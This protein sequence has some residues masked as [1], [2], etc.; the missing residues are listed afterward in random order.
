MRLRTR[1]HSG[2]HT[3]NRSEERT[4]SGYQEPLVP[5]PAEPSPELDRKAWEGW[6]WPP[7]D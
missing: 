2:K 3:V 6:S 7:V 1:T 4:A 5:H